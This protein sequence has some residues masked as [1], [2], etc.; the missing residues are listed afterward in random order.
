MEG[1]GRP[2]GGSQPASCCMIISASVAVALRFGTIDWVLGGGG[3]SEIGGESS[4][5]EDRLSGTG[6]AETSETDEEESSEP[7]DCCLGGSCV[8]AVIV[9]NEEETSSSAG[10]DCN[11]SGEMVTSRYPG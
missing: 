3:S 5:I 6:R 7:G 8:S 4:E 2:G 1:A 11:R 10:R 9:A